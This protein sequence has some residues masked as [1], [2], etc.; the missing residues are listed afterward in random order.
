MSET[1]IH[2]APT[3]L[4]TVGEAL[5]QVTRERDGIILTTPSYNK[6][7]SLIESN[8]RQIVE[9]ALIYDNDLKE[10]FL[11][12]NHFTSLCERDNV[13]MYI[14][15]NQQNQTGKA[16]TREDLKTIKNISTP[17]N[18][19]L[20]SD[21]LHMA[22]VRPKEDFA[23]FSALSEEDD[24]VL[25]ASCLGKTFNLASIT[26]SYFVTKD[27]T[28]TKTLTEVTKEVYNVGNASSLAL[29]AIEAA[30]N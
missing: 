2:N 21:E 13:S 4:F 12:V 26:H 20:M 29:A 16:G 19:N 30:Y 5:R 6:F 10:Y 23:S 8:N 17:K 27:R 7:P 28:L 14:H 22:F 15:C 1:D 3:V 24:E 11:D 9:S 18:K 25:V